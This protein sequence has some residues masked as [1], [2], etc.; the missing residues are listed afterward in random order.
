MKMLLWLRRAI[1]RALI[2]KMEVCT[3]VTIVNGEVE[4]G[5]R[6]GGAIVEKVT[7]LS[8]P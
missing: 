7:F 4:Y 3:N 5:G 8:R 1:V 2:G 6:H